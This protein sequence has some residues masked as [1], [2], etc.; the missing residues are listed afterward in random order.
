MA[1]KILIAD[2]EADVV[3]TVRF[4]L[5]SEGFEVVTAVNGLE[6]LGAARV[7]Q[8]DLVILDV[9]MPGENGYRVARM[10]REDQEA[11]VYEETLR[12]LLL[13]ARDLRKDPEREKTLMEFSGADR[14]IY[15]PFEL[16][17]LVEAVHG[18]LSLGA[19]D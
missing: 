15:K 4:R 12:I 11:G 14:A 16:D 17:D 2:D 1:A 18:L 7:H 5:E 9:M 8:P 13:T 10:L 6:A 19:S 3:E